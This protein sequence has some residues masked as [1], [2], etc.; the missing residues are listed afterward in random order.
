MFYYYRLNRSREEIIAHI[1]ANAQ[2]PTLKTVI[3]YN[4]KLSYEQLKMYAELLLQKG[5]IQKTKDGLWV[6]T[7]NGRRFL[8]HYQTIAEIIA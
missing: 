6:V 4:A 7:D 1:L 3:M 5:L 8:R 2:E